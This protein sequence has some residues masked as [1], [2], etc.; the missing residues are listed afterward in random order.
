MPLNLSKLRSRHAAVA[1]FA[2]AAFANAAR[3]PSSA[4]QPTSSLTFKCDLPSAIDPSIDGLPSAE[5]QFF[6]YHAMIRQVERLQAVAR[7]PTVCFEDLRPFDEDE[8]WKPFEE[9]HAVVEM[10][11][12]IIHERAVVETIN[13]FGLVYTIHGSDS[14]LSPILLT[15]HQDVVPVEE[16][17]S[18][19]EHP[20]FEAHFDG[21]S[22][23]GPGVIQDKGVLT[24]VMSAVESLLTDYSWMPERT[25]LLA[26]GFDEECSGSHGAAEISQFL[27]SRYGQDGI[28]AILDEGGQGLQSLGDTL[29]ALPAVYEKG[30]LGVWFDLDVVGGPSSNPPPHTAIGI[31]SEL[32]VALEEIKFRPEVIEDGPVHRHLQCQARY[33]PDADRELTELVHSHNLDGMANHLSQSHETQYLIQTSQAVNRINGIGKLNSLP[34]YVYLGTDFRSAP[35]DDVLKLQRAIV[36]AASKV[37]SKYDLQLQAFED[38]KAYQK[39]AKN[40]G[41]SKSNPQRDLNRNGTLNLRAKHIS[42]VTPISPTEGLVWDILAGTIRHSFSFNGTVVPVGE[43]MLGNTDSRHYLG[44]SSHVYRWAPIRN[45]AFENFRTANERVRMTAHMEMVGFYYDLIRNLNSGKRSD[46]I[47]LTSEL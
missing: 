12:P 7:I 45:G 22:L 37:S 31:M 6:S 39:S 9:M 23:W 18:K 33:S 3:L 47:F 13:R 35:Q 29:Y 25:L 26:V 32:V 28:A 19:W 14:T 1:F 44:L 16:D 46:A 34:G 17:M 42:D 8:R 30:Y 36:D 4:R 43:T 11:Y 21:E 20:P 24:A 38:D 27:G 5:E 41:S 2:L 10:T 15:A 40:A